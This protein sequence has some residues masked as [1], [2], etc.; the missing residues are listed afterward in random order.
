MILVEDRMFVMN[1]EKKQ[2][3]KILVAQSDQEL[4]EELKTNGKKKMEEVFHQEVLIA[5]VKDGHELIEVNRSFQPDI[6]LMDI[7][8]PQLD[9]IG[10]LEQWNKKKEIS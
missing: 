6:I 3:I 10:V 8:L 4:I 5:S 7:I 9:G 2:Q 1:E